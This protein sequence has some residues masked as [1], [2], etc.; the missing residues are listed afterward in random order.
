MRKLRAVNRHRLAGWAVAVEMLGGA[1]VA[2][3]I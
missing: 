1:E 2:V 3:A